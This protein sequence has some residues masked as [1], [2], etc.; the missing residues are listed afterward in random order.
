MYRGQPARYRARNGNG[1]KNI[2][3]GWISD[4]QDPE[5]TATMYRLFNSTQ[6]QFKQFGVKVDKIDQ[7]TE[8]SVTE[9]DVKKRQDLVKE[10][11]R[12]QL[13]HWGTGIPYTMLGITNNLTWNYLKFV[14]FTAFATWH[15]VAT[16]WYIDQKDPTF[17]GRPA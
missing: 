1:N 16:G 2:W 13:R 7:L 15:Q 12:E 9:L 3:Y 11:Q 10:I 6:P 14:E 17:Q 4:I 5:P 8:Q